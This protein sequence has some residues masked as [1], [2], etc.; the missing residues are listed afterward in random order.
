MRTLILFRGA[1][2]C[3][4]S[5][6]I[7]DHGLEDYTLSADKLRLMHKSLEHFPDGRVCISQSSDT[8]VWSTLFNLLEHRMAGGDFTVIDAT[9]SKASEINRYKELAQKYRYRIFYIDMTD[10]PIEECKRRNKLRP[11]YK[12]VPEEVIDTM[13]SRFATQSISG[14]VT[15]LTPQE[16]IDGA[17]FMRPYDLSRYD[18]IHHIGDIHGCN[19]VLQQYLDGGIKPNEYYIFCGDYIDRGP[20]NVEVLKFLYKI[21]DLP[22]VYLLEGN[23]ERHLYRWALGN[24]VASDEFN[25]VTAKQLEV[26]S[27]LD[28]KEIRKLCRKFCQCAYYT[29]RGKTVLVT[30]G[31]IAKFNPN[32]TSDLT[33]IATRHMV[34][35][36]GKYAD[37]EVCDQTFTQTMPE[38]FYQI[39]GHRNIY[40]VPIHNTERTF[41][42]EGSVERGG[43]L[44]C[45]Q[46][47]DHGFVCVDI[48]NQKRKIERVIVAE[49]NQDIKQT[50]EKL[51]DDEYVQEKKFGHISSF[52][53]TKDAFY[54]KHWN[55]MTVKA[56]GL[57]INNHTYQIIA[58]SYKKFFNVNE[59]DETKLETMQSNLQFPVTAYQKE[60]G[61]LGII[62]YDTAKHD[63]LITSKSS[64]TSINSEWF[65][66]ILNTTGIDVSAITTY[67]KQNRVSL[68]CEVIDPVN[69]PHII[70]YDSPHVVL[71]DVVK[72]QLEY[73]KLPYDELQRLGAKFKM[74]VK[75]Q[76]HV[77][78]NW[79]EFMAWYQTVCSD[80]YQYNGEY[81]EGFVF[82]DTSGF[83]CKVKTEYYNMWK[84]LRSVARNTLH[85]GRFNRLNALQKPIM[86]Q[87]YGWVQSKYT[88]LPEET[89]IIELRK[90]FFK[91][92][93]Q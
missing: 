27:F 15:K 88:L 26:D 20:D 74:C 10:V 86:N 46:L 32:T 93:T 78:N 23:H 76:T 48:P 40:G 50:V 49:A 44:R 63:L 42:L 69:D 36:V 43:S 2:G 77:L 5:T 91:E 89:S 56:R 84:F 66:T 21:K 73:E 33:M 60:N 38:N 92:I 3:G 70:E 8:K 57:F 37:S 16:F 6:F 18:R 51:R 62:G 79:P 28:K 19:S 1:P 29:Y 85:Y 90:M 72:N 55:E 87:F 59:V 82:E 31:G 68:V 52:N 75:K 25:N 4:K 9:N 35:G 22:N 83:M 30:H 80:D 45:V 34:H 24:D 53:F 12:Q 41:N 47:A 7:R 58:R 54:D 17:A 39:H 67:L 81:V 64:P 71:L 13:Y 14:G 65:K 61:F 11:E